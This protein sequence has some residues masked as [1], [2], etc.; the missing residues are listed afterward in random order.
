MRLERGFNMRR[1]LAVLVALLMVLTVPAC[2]AQEEP[3]QEAT[4]NSIVLAAASDSGGFSDVPADAWYAGAVAYVSESGLMNGVG[5]GRFDPDGAFTRA[6]LSTVLYRIEGEPSVDAG[7]SFTDV[8][9][10]AWYAASAA[11]AKQNG[12][13]NGVGGGRFAPDTPVTQEMLVTMLW[14]M[15]KEPRSETASDASVY[16]ATA[17]GWARARNIAPATK[18]YAFSPKENVSRAQVAVLLHNYLTREETPE[19]NEIT[20]TVSGKRLTVEWAENAS[21]DALRELLEKG[22]LTVELSQYG[23]FEQVGALGTSLPRNDVQTTTK[24]GDIMLYSGSQIVVFYGSNSWAYTRL[25]RITGMSGEELTALLGVGGVTAVLSLAGEKTETAAFDF[26]TRT[27]RLN[28]GYD[29][30]ILGLGTWTLSNEQ[31]EDA[32]YHALKDGYR[33]I[34]TARYYGNEAGVGKGIQKAIREGIVNREDVFVTSKVMPSDYSRAAQGIDDSLRDLGLDYLDLMLIHQPGSNDKAVYQAL[35]QGVR[36]GKLRSIG[37]SNYY[38]K[39]A[40]DEVLSYAEITPAVVQNENHLYYQNTAL[41]DYV[42]QYGTVV[43]SWY[44]FGGR[45]HTQEH[46]GNETVQTVAAAHGKTA[47]QVILRWQLQAGFI[48]IPGSGNPEHIAENYDVF[49]FELSDAEMARIVALDRQQ[50]YE[51]W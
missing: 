14:R 34:D 37:I 12:V 40:F 36:D 28:S 23:G 11:W 18:D 32:V 43:E 5:S 16:A 26:R 35:E 50:R 39:A 31:A 42:R 47:A 19:M 17:V 6:Q 46:F 27:V 4:G 24:P 9:P 2:A 51:N 25:G 15:E 41:R 21:V 49:D 48:A 3:T 10:G 1:T 38:T 20:L 22:P 30:P 45:G 29:M 13:I 33:L 44:P 8:A 7:N